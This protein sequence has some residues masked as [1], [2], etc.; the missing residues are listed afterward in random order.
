VQFARFSQN[1]VQEEGLRS[2][3]GEG[4]APLAHYLRGNKL[5]PFQ[6]NL[7]KAAGMTR[8]CA[9]SDTHLVGDAATVAGCQC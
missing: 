8:V 7:P 9:I 6:E 5:D 3:Q 4:K 1:T 2:M